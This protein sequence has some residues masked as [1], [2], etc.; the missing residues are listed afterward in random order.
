MSI[1]AQILTERG[2]VPTS[3]P[4][5]RSSSFQARCRTAPR[6]G[7]LRASGPDVADADGGHRVVPK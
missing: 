4:A 1:L 3:A 6:T 2:H 5:S 7:F